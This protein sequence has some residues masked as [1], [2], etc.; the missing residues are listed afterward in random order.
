MTTQ[1]ARNAIRRRKRQVLT[2]ASGASSSTININLVNPTTG[3]AVNL[4]GPLTQRD[5]LLGMVDTVRQLTG[6]R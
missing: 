4:N 3:V 5:T 6:A 2:S 1:T